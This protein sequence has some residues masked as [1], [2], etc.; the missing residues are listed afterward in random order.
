VPVALLLVGEGCE[1]ARQPPAPLPTS[2][3]EAQQENPPARNPSPSAA[4]SQ[5]TFRSFATAGDA[6]GAILRDQPRIIG[7][8]EVHQRSDGPKVQPA[9][10]RFRRQLLPRLAGRATDL[11]VET[12]VAAGACGEQEQ[13]VARKV[14]EETKRPAETESAVVR[15]L[16]AAKNHGVRPH[17]LTLR[18]EE[19]DELTAG[20]ALQ[21]DK[22]L[23]LIT[24]HLTARAR[25]IYE[26]R[27]R[28]SRS[29]RRRAR[30][31]T[32]RSRRGMQAADGIV[33][34]YGGA[35]HNDVA[36]HPEL[37]RYSY[38]AALRELSGDRYV[39]VDLVV[40]ELALGNELFSREPWYPLLE[41]HTSKERVLLVPRQ[42][43]SSYVIL[44]RRGVPD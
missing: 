9:L 38:A 29:H 16:E 40:P 4:T 17:I 34:I 10:T 14:E 24:R 18:C 1:E 35:L 41:Q 6:L 23:G 26:L 11:L 31:R 15:L 30:Q 3:P 42:V 2:A 32:L 37:A 7:F 5:P 12:W 28:P 27:Q 36:P 25:R 33:A 13:R 19:Y 8:G 43:G 21:Y 44:L 22:L 39:E 20:E